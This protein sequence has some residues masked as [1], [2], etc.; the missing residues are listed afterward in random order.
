MD[1]NNTIKVPNFMF[2][3]GYALDMHVIIK[4]YKYDAPILQ[5]EW[6]HYRIC[7]LYIF[8]G[9]L[10]V[11]VGFLYMILVSIHGVYIQARYVLDVF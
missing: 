7:T 2:K 8:I 10:S 6:R 5:R 1:K 3:Y 4:H 11:I 9:F